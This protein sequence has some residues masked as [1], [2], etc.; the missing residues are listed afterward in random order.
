[1][2]YSFMNFAE[3]STKNRVAV[4]LL[5]RIF[6][7]SDVRGRVIERIENINQ[8]NITLR[9][10][11]SKKDY[12]DTSQFKEHI[13]DKIQKNEEYYTKEKFDVIGDYYYY[14]VKNMENQYTQ[15]PYTIKDKAISYSYDHLY[16]IINPYSYEINKNSYKS[17]IETIKTIFNSNKFYYEFYNENSNDL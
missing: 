3:Y 14:I 12:H 13:L 4:E 2:V 17:F 7:H 5:K 15:N 16:G 10:Y 6:Q 1:M 11:F 9:F 8:K